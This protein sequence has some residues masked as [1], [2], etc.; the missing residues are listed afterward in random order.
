MEQR[1]SQEH[2][3]PGDHTAAGGD[4]STDAG[5]TTEFFMTQMNY[6]ALVSDMR[7]FMT[8]EGR[9]PSCGHAFRNERDIQIVHILPPRHAQDWARLHTGNIR[10]LCGSCNRTKAKKTSLNGL[11]NKKAPG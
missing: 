7:A 2:P 1:D 3:A 9:C 4:G 6:A 10:F 11:M 8:D 5:T